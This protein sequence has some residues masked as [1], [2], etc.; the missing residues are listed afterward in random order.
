[1]MYV[2]IKKIY[3]INVSVHNT[4]KHITLTYECVFLYTHVYSKRR[5]AQDKKDKK[6][7]NDDKDISQYD[8]RL[9]F[10]SSPSFSIVDERSMTSFVGFIS[11]IFTFPPNI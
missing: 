1:M 2:K 8:V 11:L 3:M 6:F 4:L 7:Y 9:L 10:P 5:R